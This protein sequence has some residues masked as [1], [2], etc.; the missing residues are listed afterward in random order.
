[1][2]MGKLDFRSYLSDL[3]SLYIQYITQWMEWQIEPI[4]QKEF[5][6]FCFVFLLQEIHVYSYSQV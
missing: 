1:M 2:G 4:A 6:F 3:S 5:L